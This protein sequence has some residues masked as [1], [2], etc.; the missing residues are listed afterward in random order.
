LEFLK[1]KYTHRESAL[2]E[3]WQGFEMQDH[4]KLRHGHE[5]S[6]QDFR[7][8]MKA[9]LDLSLISRT[10]LRSMAPRWKEAI[11]QLAWR[12]CDG[13]NPNTKR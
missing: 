11:E 2:A 6:R 3:L 10:V 12:G 7:S 5:L 4:H 9:V 13:S 8:S 1:S